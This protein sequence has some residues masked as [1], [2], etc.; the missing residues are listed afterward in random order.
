MKLWISSSLYH[1]FHESLPSFYSK[2]LSLGNARQNMCLCHYGRGHPAGLF[3]KT[4]RRYGPNVEKEKKM[5]RALKE[6]ETL[7]RDDLF[8]LDTRNTSCHRNKL[9]KTGAWND[10]EKVVSS[11]LQWFVSRYFA[12]TIGIL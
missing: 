10:L 3:K 2:K 12:L 9:K 8:V 5:Y 11:A 1:L 6:M 4:Y 7:D